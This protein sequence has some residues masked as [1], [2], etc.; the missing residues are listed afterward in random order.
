MWFTLYKKFPAS[1]FQL[2][3]LFRRNDKSGKNAVPATRFR[4]NS[5]PLTGD[6]TLWGASDVGGGIT[7]CRRTHLNGA[8]GIAR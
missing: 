6:I 1:S 2:Q 3:T 4:I 5:K 7:N 8:L